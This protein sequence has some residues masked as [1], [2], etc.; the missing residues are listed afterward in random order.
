MVVIITVLFFVPID[1]LHKG[2][3][4][5]DIVGSVLCKLATEKDDKIYSFEFETE[6]AKYVYT[7]NCKCVDLFIG[8]CF[9]SGMA[10]KIK[11]QK[12]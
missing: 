8:R 7:V 10:E 12:W 3:N 2:N 11:E 5:S 4:T 6:R 1:S 9:V